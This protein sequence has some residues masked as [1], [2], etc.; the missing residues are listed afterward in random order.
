MTPKRVF[1]PGGCL[2]WESVDDSVVLD[3][4]GAH[5]RLVLWVVEQAAVDG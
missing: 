4:E 1:H 5:S 2:G 3:V